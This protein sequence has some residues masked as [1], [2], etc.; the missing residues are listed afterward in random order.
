MLA[1]DEAFKQNIFI[2]Q[3]VPMDTKNNILTIHFLIE[4]RKLAIVLS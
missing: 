4:I 2:I 3:D 1:I